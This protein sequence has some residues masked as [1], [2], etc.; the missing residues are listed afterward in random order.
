MEV[1]CDQIIEECKKK[2]SDDTRYWSD[3][4]LQQFALAPHWSL[5][6]GYQFWRKVE[7][8]RKGSNVAWTPTI[9]RNS[10]TFEQS[11]DIQEVQSILY[12]KTM[13]CYQ[14]VSPSFFHGGNGKELR[15]I[16]I[17][18]LIPGGVSLKT[19]RQ[20]VFFTVV[21]PMDN[22]DCFGE[23]TMRLVKSKNRAYKNTWRPFQDIV[24][25]SNL[26]L[27]RQRGLQ[28]YQTRSNAVFLYDT[29]P[30][31]FMEKA[32]CMKTRDQLYQR[33]TWF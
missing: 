18:G 15:S 1:H 11:N 28:F 16:V 4:M 20:A 10:C 30:A 3:E 21:N 5:E 7:D 13:Y 2:V 27:A 31:E 25:W 23:N 29:Q 14:K 32:I 9:V 17:H 19:G 6:N 12:C 8:R 22:Q 33:E 24:F 26:K